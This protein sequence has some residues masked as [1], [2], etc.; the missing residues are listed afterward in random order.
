MLKRRRTGV[1]SAASVERH[2]S[3]RKTT[4]MAL[5]RPETRRARSRRAGE[6]AARYRPAPAIW[7]P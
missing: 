2:T 6:E 3:V 1:R 7:G 5:P 4:A